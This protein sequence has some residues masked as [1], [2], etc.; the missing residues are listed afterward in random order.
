MLIKKTPDKDFTYQDAINYASEEYAEKGE[1]F[2][3]SKVLE[4]FDEGCE[5]D[6]DIRGTNDNTCLHWAC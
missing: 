6:V 3:V 2:L 5:F 4:R 1:W